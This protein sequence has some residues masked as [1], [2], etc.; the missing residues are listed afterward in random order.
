MPNFI[1]SHVVTKREKYAEADGELLGPS[2]RA[3]SQGDCR[4]LKYFLAL[5]FVT[6]CPDLH[7]WTWQ[8]S[9]IHCLLLF[10]SRARSLIVSSSLAI[11][12]TSNR[13]LHLSLVAY[14][15][16]CFVAAHNTWANPNFSPTRLLIVP[17]AHVRYLCYVKNVVFYFEQRELKSKLGR[18]WIT[19]EK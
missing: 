13:K 16:R 10:L 19:H 1:G 11:R 3:P 2:L 9:G 4:I 8:P 18:K 14:F 17:E 6:P 7:L 15:A 12:S 5:P